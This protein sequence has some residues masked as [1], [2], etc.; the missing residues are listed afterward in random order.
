MHL[1][2]LLIGVFYLMFVPSSAIQCYIGHEGQCRLLPELE[3]CGEDKCV[4]VKSLLQ[5]R[6]GIGS[7]C[8]PDEQKAGVRKYL[9]TRLSSASCERMKNNPPRGILSITCCST[10]RCNAPNTGECTRPSFRRRDQQIL[11]DLLNF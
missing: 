7:V 4:C 8:S 9:F 3:Y 1:Q 6:T 10:D 5:C 2:P 11:D